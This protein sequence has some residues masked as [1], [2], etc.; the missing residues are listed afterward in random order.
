MVVFAQ[1]HVMQKSFVSMLTKPPAAQAATS[2][3]CPS[4][5]CSRLA[6]VVTRRTPVAPNGCPRESDPPHRFNLSNE[7]APAFMRWNRREEGRGRRQIKFVHESDSCQIKFVHEREVQSIKFHIL[8]CCISPSYGEYVGL[9]QALLFETVM[10]ESKICKSVMLLTLW[11]KHI[12]T[13]KQKTTT[14]KKPQKI[15]QTFNII[16]CLVVIITNSSTPSFV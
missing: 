3:N 6:A 9:L 13:N 4:S 15:P 1:K 12:W 5:L 14:Q 10:L 2:A 16:F 8:R 11:P 7:G